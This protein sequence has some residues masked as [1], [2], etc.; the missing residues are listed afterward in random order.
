MTLG[1]TIIDKEIP[2]NQFVKFLAQIPYIYAIAVNI[3]FISVTR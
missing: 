1:L 3:N 2:S